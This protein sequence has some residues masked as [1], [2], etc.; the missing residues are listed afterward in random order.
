[1]SQFT[2]TR[3]LRFACQKARKTT[4]R[5][6]P[7]SACSQNSILKINKWSSIIQDCLVLRFLFSLIKQSF[8]GNTERGTKS[9]GA[10]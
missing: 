6:N 2:F 5:L 1:M 7:A 9:P 8:G 4:K 3:K 10:S